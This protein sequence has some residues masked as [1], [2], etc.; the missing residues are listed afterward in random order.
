MAKL[1]TKK[2]TAITF[3]LRGKSGGRRQERADGK[4]VEFSCTASKL[5]FQIKKPPVPFQA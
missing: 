4:C 5:T 2:T 1:K 3:L